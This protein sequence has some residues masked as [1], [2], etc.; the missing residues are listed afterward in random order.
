M[1][2]ITL[3]NFG[4]TNKRAVIGKELKRLKKKVILREMIWIVIVVLIGDKKVKGGIFLSFFSVFLFMIIGT[5]KD[6]RRD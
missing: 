6:E 2:I 4:V 5:K 3:I 1:G